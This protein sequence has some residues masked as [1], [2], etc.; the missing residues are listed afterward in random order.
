[1]KNYIVDEC[2][3]SRDDL[4]KMIDEHARNGWEVISTLWLPARQGYGGQHRDADF[5][6]QFVVVLARDAPDNA[7]PSR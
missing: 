5:A 2:A 4:Q 6:A 7:Q 3:D 1:M